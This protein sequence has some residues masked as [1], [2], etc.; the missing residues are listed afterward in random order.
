M[1]VLTYRRALG[2]DTFKGND[3]TRWGKENEIDGIRAFERVTGF[4]VQ[5][6]R[7][8]THPKYAWLAGSPGDRCLTHRIR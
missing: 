4:N 8:H 5:A 3:A 2:V 6:T 7:L 1:E